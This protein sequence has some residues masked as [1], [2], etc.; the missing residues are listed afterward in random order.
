[1]D[2][3]AFA[4]E[5]AEGLATPGLVEQSRASGFEPADPD[6]IRAGRAPKTHERIGLA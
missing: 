1:M 5:Y 3:Q 2:R 6:R 4:S